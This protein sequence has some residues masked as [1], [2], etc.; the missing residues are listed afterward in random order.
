MICCL[1]RLRLSRKNAPQ[2][3]RT[4]VEGQTMWGRE[5]KQIQYFAIFFVRVAVFVSVFLRI[6]LVRLEPI[7]AVATFCQQWHPHAEGTF[8]FFDHKVTN[9]VEFA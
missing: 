6:R 8:H 3:R 2:R 7:G 1:R 4:V 5:W 9:G